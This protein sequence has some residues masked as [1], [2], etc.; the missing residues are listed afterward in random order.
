MLKKLSIKLAFAAL[1]VLPVWAVAG[2]DH[3]GDIS[4][5]AVNGKLIVGGSHFETHGVTGFNIYEADFG[6]LASGP[7]ATKDPGFQTQAGGL[8]KPGA[9]ISF[10]GLGAL[11]FWNGVNWGASAAAYGVTIADVYQDAP[12]TWTF[13]G[14]SQ[15]ETQYVSEVSAGGTIHDH[16]KMSVTPNAPVG[17]YL[18]EL[19]LKSD[20]YAASDSF[21]IVFNR[22]LSEAAFESSVDALVTAPV[23]EPSSYILMLAGMG[24]IG[25]LARRRRR[26]GV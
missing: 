25:L 16:L 18:I 10:E 22:G 7:W 14:V 1:A 11:S 4:V 24:A 9:L 17:A 3:A 19:K 5:S 6:D 20:D 26:A 21:Y 13:G 15:G 8:L 12:T 23:P 2:E